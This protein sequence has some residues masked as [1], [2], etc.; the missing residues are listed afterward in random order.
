LSNE[1]GARD[2]GIIAY[3]CNHGRM[4]ISAENMI[5]E[6]VDVITQNP[7]KPCEMGAVLV[8]DLNNFVMPRIRYKL[9]DLAVISQT[10]CDCGINL[11]VI[12]KLQGREDDIFLAKDGTLVHSEY[13]TYI[14]RSMDGIKQFQML[15]HTPNSVTFTIVKTDDFKD[16][17][18]E[19]IV[20]SIKDKLGVTDINLVY[21]D[22]IPVEGSGKYRF[23]KREFPLDVLK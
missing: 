17:S 15:Q 3:T 6:T 4:H 16:E 9:G 2:G 20:N 14:A 23:T 5:F 13:F 21:T 18:A 1:Y 19:L 12:E 11:P 10:S 8:T 7:I 22:D